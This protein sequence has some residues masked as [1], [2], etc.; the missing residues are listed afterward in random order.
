MKMK[1]RFGAIEEFSFEPMISG[2]PLQRAP[3]AKQLHITL[4]IT[5]WLSKSMTG[6]VVRQPA[7]NTYCNM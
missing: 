7:S 4:C 1:R 5:G 6:K 2:G 3:T